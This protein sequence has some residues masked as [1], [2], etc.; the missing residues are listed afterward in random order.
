MGFLTDWLTDWLK[1]LLIEGIMGNLTGLFD[2]VNSRVGEIAVQVGTTPAAWNAGVFSLIRQLSE[3][4]I[5]PI[6]GLILT[7]VATYEL[8]QL[9]I[10]KNNLHD[11]DY[12]IFFKWIFKTACAILILSNTFNIVMAVFDVSQSVIARAAGIVQGSTDISEAML[13]DLESTLEALEI[14]AN[15]FQFFTRNPRG[16]RA[17]AID[18]ADAAALRALLTAESFGP[19]VAHAPYTI[20]P[21]SKDER[22]REFA[23]ETLADDL[24]RM[25]YLPGNLYNFHPGSHTGQGTDA[26]IAQIADTLNAILR[27]EQQTTVLLE[28][29]AGKGTEVGRRFEELR[30]IIDRVELGEKLGVCLDTCHTFAAGYDLATLEG[31]E[32]TFKRFDELIGFSYLAGMHLNDSKSKLGG[33]LDRHNSIGKGELGWETFRRL[34]ADPRLDNIPLVL[35]TIDETLWKQEIAILQA[36]SRN[37]NPELPW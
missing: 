7:F 12:W 29:M 2:T 1:E 32:A 14:G 5:L 18:P 19:I 26:G 8:I 37:E 9:I 6:A 20:N 30:A 28:T 23:R 33:K 4:V 10:E 24:A 15:T 21:C 16:S 22:T 34:M 3:T 31:C 13:A 17:K 27:P 25:E 35:E 36:F 11:L